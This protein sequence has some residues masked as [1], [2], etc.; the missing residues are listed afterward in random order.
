VVS[1]IFLFPVWPET[2]V[3]GH[4][5][6]ITAYYLAQ[7]PHDLRIVLRDVK[8]RPYVISEPEVVLAAILDSES[9]ICRVSA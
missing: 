1:A 6:T 5:R 2:A 7:L 3:G 4:F 9:A 8:R